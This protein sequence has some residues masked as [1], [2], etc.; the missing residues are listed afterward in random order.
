MHC[1]VLRRL[2]LACG[3]LLAACL[4]FLVSL[5]DLAAQ[6]PLANPVEVVINEV[7]WGG[8]AANATDEWIELYNNTGVPI[9]LTGWTLTDGGDISVILSGTIPTNDHYLLERTDDNTVSDVPADLIYTGGLDN[10]GEGLQLFD[11]GGNLI[12]T[13]NATGGPW[14]AGSG[15]P[16]YYSME[17]IDPLAPD[18]PANW[19]A[20]NGL[21]RNG[22]DATGNPVNGTPR[23]PNSAATP[24]PAP[25]EVVINEVAWGGTAANAADEWIELF[26]VAPQT[27]SLTGWTITST[28]GL[29]VPLSG[30]ISSHGYYLL[31][32][33]D[34][35]TISDIPADLIYTGGL[36]ND[37]ETLHLLDAS[38]GLIA[39]AN[40]AGGSWP[41]GSGSPGHYSM[42]RTDPLA[43]DL[44][45][46]WASNNSLIRNGLDANGDPLN[47][48]PKQPNS[49][50]YPVLPGEVV[51]NEVAWSGTQADPADEWIELYNT[52]A[53]T[54]ALDGWWLAALDG[55]PVITLTGAISPGGYFLIER[56]D[57]DPVADLTADLALPF[58]GDLADGGETL[59]LMTGTLTIDTA[60]GD[61]GP[62][63]AGT[64]APDYRS[65]ER[66]APTVSDTDTNWVANNTVQR[67]GTDAAGNPIN[68]TP[69]AA[70]SSTVP[71]ALLISEFLYDAVTPTTAG[72]E[73]VELCSAES[74]PIDL[75]G[76]KVGDEETPGG[77]ESMYHLPNG[78]A[79]APD[80]CLVI[81]K[82]AAQFAARFGF[83]PGFELV[84]TGSGYTDTPAVPELARYTAWGS[85]SWALADDGDELLVL[86][87]T[88]QLVDSAAYRNGDYAAA[89]V[90]PEASALE[91]DSLQRVWPF[92]T[93][94]M[95]ADF[96]RRAP[97][98]GTITS[99]PAPP[100]SS[101]PTADLPGGMRAYWGIL[102]SQSSYS[103]GA[104]PP[105][106][107]FATARA[108]GLHFMALTDHGSKLTPEEWA[109]VGTRAADASLPG[110]FIALRG[111]EYAHPDEGHIT[112][113]NTPTFVA[114][115]DPLYDTLPEFYA[116]LAAQPDALAEF[117]QPFNNSDFHD[118]AYDS[119]VG[120]HICLL[121][122]G[123]G[124]ELYNQYHTFEEQ[125]MRAL[126]TGWRVAPANNSD[127]ENA[128]WG[129]DTAH[130]TGLV[131]PALTEADLL[132]A[133]RARRAFATEDSNLAL[134]LRS[135]V[136]W[137][138]ST[139]SHA[140]TLTFT[141]NALDLDSM[142][143]PITLSL[144]DRALPVA[145]ATFPAPPVEWTATLPGQP[146]H[147]YW[148]RAV[149]ADGDVAQTAPLWTD[150]TPTP[151][152]VLLNEI[153]PAPNAV[154][155]D[156]DG[157][158]D[159]QDEWIEI[160]NAGDTAVGLG[161]WQVQDASGASHVIPL[162]TTLSP[163][164]YLVLYQRETGLA[165]NNDAETV[166]LL[167]LDGGT[168]D[169]YQ[170]GDGPSYDVGLCRLPDV[171]GDWNDRCD[172]TPGGPNRALPVPGPVETTV[173]E[174]RR[175]P[176]GSWVRLRGQITVPPGVFSQQ[177]AYI[178]DKTGGIK[179]YLP[180]DHR[181]WA[182]LGD[183]VEV[184]GNTRMYHGELEIGVSERQDVRLLEPGDPVPPLPI[185]TGV[186]VE[187]YEGTL[188]LL[189]GWAVDF[190]RG[191]HFWAD[192]GT[193]WARI[194][195][196][197]DTGIRRPWLEVGQP[198]HQ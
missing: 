170:Y 160:Y 26:N 45:E 99:P 161:G 151:E 20:N 189:S 163:G 18:S 40:V 35:D 193:S 8:T 181:F 112:V 196:D 100:A 14:P 118:F 86:G 117:N 21:T 185:G 81:A 142:S 131:A 41:A 4:L 182:N 150:G 16:D 51:I 55:A 175:L 39:T 114:H 70:N 49:I 109:D 164:G 148:A 77:G 154:D 110:E 132:E 96:V 50:T 38:G 19:T 188:V 103:N 138:G 63:P 133:I 128:Y 68:G 191:G 80:E 180:K 32:R 46:N 197:P 93:D 47:G 31:E 48:T 187:P 60:N 178:Q 194:Y 125:W 152:A 173:F 146:G 140:T 43:P 198:V 104:G 7:A 1:T 71:P 56:D 141:V 139:I 162:N 135:G 37:G 165:L 172:P 33:T 108:N 22:L 88:D 144:Y 116:W 177:T 58:N 169:S 94:S 179:I 98:P 105:L 76:F 136:V 195:L 66:L 84:V 184:T 57:D 190:E 145:S 153:L 24:P 171:T 87:P 82:N 106:M 72:D 155:W 29:D 85:G 78:R 74:A 42:E 174:S 13:A 123:S 166:T 9:D 52:A 168:A 69:R 159:Y 11:D 30:L 90:A 126:A 27:I 130:R 95:P 64:G 129:A 122:V 2:W 28:G 44:P 53:S 54:I 113:W 12:D 65:M 61:G 156:S 89:G 17:R 75:T 134:T 158:A 124:S 147:F 97:N 115:D 6:A 3:G 34:D 79:L 25:G 36:G 83:Y 92:D 91:P 176:L 107:A 121:E 120:S 67:N 137:M 5:S 192:D 119:T 102:H 167:R 143:E 183:R 157:T 23:Q 127:S 101:P 73:F 59:R 186:M 10:G 15:S 149:Q 111:Y 62:W